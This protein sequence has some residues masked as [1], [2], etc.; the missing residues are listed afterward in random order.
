MIKTHLIYA[1]II[2][3]LIA[4][5]LW[6]SN[7]KDSE[8]SEQK[9]IEKNLKIKIDSLSWIVY[10]NDIIKKEIDNDI[11]KYKN[12]ISILKFEYKKIIRDNYHII[13]AD[14]RNRAIEFLA[15]EK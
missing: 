6:I 10:Q 2:A 4:G 13:P 3:G 15:A 9:K 14:D 5:I 8:I 11:K 12:E 1:V 7:S